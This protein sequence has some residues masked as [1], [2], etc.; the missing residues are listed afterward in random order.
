MWNVKKIA[1]ASLESQ[2]R[3]HSCKKIES[4]S[5]DKPARIRN[6]QKLAWFRWIRET[7]VRH[8]VTTER[9]AVPQI[10]QWSINH[11]HPTVHYWK[12][13]RC[14]VCQTD[15]L[16][17]VVCFNIHFGKVDPKITASVTQ[18]PKSNISFLFDIFME[19][20]SSM[21]I[22]QYLYHCQIFNSTLSY[23][24]CKIGSLACST[25]SDLFLICLPLWLKV[26]SSRTRESNKCNVTHCLHPCF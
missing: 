6:L 19:Y 25:H 24:D 15:T 12:S 7:K 17:P 22:N 21:N 20:P 1:W 26:Q 14:T 4:K 23:S 3:V 5:S 11:L 9:S 18:Y 8:T 2:N 13:D 16:M 10:F